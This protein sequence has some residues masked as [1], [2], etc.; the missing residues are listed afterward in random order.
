M[1]AH[2]FDVIIKA[3]IELHTMVEANTE[4]EAKEMAVLELRGGG[5]ITNIDFDRCMMLDDEDVDIELMR[6][7]ENHSRLNNA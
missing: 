1:P 2:Q 6:M 3:E 5:T 4:A 7:A